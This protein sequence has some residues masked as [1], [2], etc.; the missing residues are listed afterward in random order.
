ML[1]WAGLCYGRYHVKVEQLR[2]AERQGRAA[3]PDLCLGY[4]QARALETPRCVKLRSVKLIPEPCS[5]RAI[6]A[7][8][9]PSRDTAGT[10]T[11]KAHA[12]WTRRTSSTC[13]FRPGAE[14]SCLDKAP[15]TRSISGFLIRRDLWH[16]HLAWAR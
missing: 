10:R 5:L 6:G 16:S 1:G 14:S 15:S 13:P 11:S 9:V 2:A 8:A 3:L 4:K 12:V 7:S